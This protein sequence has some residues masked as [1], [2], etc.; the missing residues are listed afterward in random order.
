MYIEGPPFF[1]RSF[2]E[3]VVMNSNNLNGWSNARESYFFYVSLAV[4]VAMIIFGFARE[5]LARL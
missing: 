5:I 4:V 3:V 1:P 2:G